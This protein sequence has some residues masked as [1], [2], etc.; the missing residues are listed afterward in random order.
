MLTS[1]APVAQ[2]IEQPPPKRQVRR[3]NRPR[4]TFFSPEHRIR[5]FGGVAKMVIAPACQAGDRGFETRRFRKEL[6][7][8]NHGC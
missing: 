5:L 7:V 6:N 8:T 3:S 1:C 2:G 4:G